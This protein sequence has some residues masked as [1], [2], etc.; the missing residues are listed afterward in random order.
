[1]TTSPLSGPGQWSSTALA[2]AAEAL[3]AP[4]TTVRPFGGGG[5]W[6]GTRSAGEAAPIAWLNARYSG[7]L[8]VLWFDAHGDLNTPQTSPSGNFHGMV[9]R[10]LL[11]EGPAPFLARLARPLRP[12][13]VFLIGARDLDP[14]ETAYLAERPLRFYPTLAEADIERLLA[15]LAASGC[16]HVY[17]HLDVDVFNPE[18]F[19]DDLLPIPGGPSLA[20]V[21]ACLEAVLAAYPQAGGG[22]CEY[23][24]TTHTSR[25]RLHT[26]LTDSGL[27]PLS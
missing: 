17:V 14:A 19:A 1:M 16:T 2:M 20:S 5:R 6:A 24:G 18:S 12:D 8:A 7:R 13:Q 3:P 15:D 23:R 9:L 4:T 27:L 25:A 22:V 21:Q 11:G 10:T 26:L